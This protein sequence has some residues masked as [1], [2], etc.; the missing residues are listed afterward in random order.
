LPGREREH[1]EGDEA[2]R[3]L[4]GEHVDA[5]L[6][7]VDALAEQVEVRLA[8]L[9][10][11]DDLAVEDAAALGQAHELREVAREVA[12]VARL[13]VGLAAVA[14]RD[15]A[16]AVPLRLVDPVVARRQRLGGL[17]E[18]G[19]HGRAE[20]ERHRPDCATCECW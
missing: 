16:V 9:A 12:A 1:V 15:A 2:R 7:G 11:D 3:R 20:R 17:G 4:L 13:Q 6:G 8:V 19:E 14:E 5:R 18:L 10:E